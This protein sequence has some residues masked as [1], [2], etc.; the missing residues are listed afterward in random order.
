[1]ITESTNEKELIRV[2]ADILDTIENAAF[3]SSKPHHLTIRKEGEG[4]SF[5]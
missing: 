3:V 1:M 2:R 4:P 5:A